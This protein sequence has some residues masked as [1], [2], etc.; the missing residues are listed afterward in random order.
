L[1]RIYYGFR[2]K[3]YSE[4]LARLNKKES[5]WYLWDWTEVISEGAR[6]EN[7]VAL[8]LFKMVCLGKDTRG[9][10]LGL[11]FLR[12]RDEREV[13]FLITKDRKPFALIECKLSEDLSNSNLFYFAERLKIPFCFVISQKTSRPRTLKNGNVTVMCLPSAAF[14]SQLGC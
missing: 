1:E 11:Y 7:M 4:K 2:I 9:E 8:H 6:F 5:K 10:E 12:D 14:L 3:S 13:D